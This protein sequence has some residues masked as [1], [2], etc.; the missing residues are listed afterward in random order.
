MNLF[1]QF[2]SSI[3]RLEAYKYF[4]RQSS[5]KAFLYLFLISIPLI[6]LLCYSL[7]LPLEGY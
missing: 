7:S 6:D 2:Y 5:G 4:F 1:A 3:T